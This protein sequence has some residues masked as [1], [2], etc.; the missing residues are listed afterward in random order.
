MCVC[1]WIHLET[2]WL[3]FDFMMLCSTCWKTGWFLRF[4]DM[5][6]LQF[7]FPT[8]IFMFVTT[9]VFHSIFVSSIPQSRGAVNLIPS[10]AQMKTVVWD[11]DIFE[12]RLEDVPATFWYGKGLSQEPHFSRLLSDW[13]SKFIR[14]WSDPLSNF[15]RSFW[16]SFRRFQCFNHQFR[17]PRQ[18]GL[19]YSPMIV[20]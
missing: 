14:W 18:M 1:V 6:I 2:R 10:T 15:F 11:C 13:F 7:R 5:S 9:S 4:S 20:Y 12:G 16:D 19:C 3:G 8:S 17:W